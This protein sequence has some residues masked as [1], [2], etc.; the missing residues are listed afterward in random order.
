M[1]VH[2][3]DFIHVWHIVFQSGKILN[4]RDCAING[5]FLIVACEDSDDRPPAWYPI[6]TVEFLDGVEV[7]NKQE[8]DWKTTDNM[9]FSIYPDI[10]ERYKTGINDQ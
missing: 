2:D 6:E 3:G 10:S 8:T 1:F 4:N 9:K 7:Y 5:R